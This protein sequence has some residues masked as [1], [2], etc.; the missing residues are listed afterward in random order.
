MIERSEP[1]GIRL[2]GVSATMQDRNRGDDHSGARCRSRCPA[3]RTDDAAR[4]E[5]LRQDHDVAHDRGLSG[6][7]QRQDLDRRARRHACAGE[8]AR[9]RLRVPEL[10]PVP[11]SD[12]F[13]QRRLRAAG[14][15]QIR[16]AKSSAAVAEAL[17]LV[18]LAGFGERLPNELS[19]GQQQRV[20]LARAIVIQPARP[21]VRRAAF[22]PGC[23]TAGLDAR[24]DQAP[25]AGAQDHDG[26]RHARPGRG[27]GD[28][29]PHRRD[30]GRPDRPARQRRSACTGVR[31]PPSSRALSDGPICCTPSSRA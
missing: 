10:C 26:L 20:A 12:D 31:R 8:P 16:A 5:R 11:A 28:F 15:Q 4:P 17:E 14:A 7:E 2:E 3:G 21:A 9:H 25:A 18:G 6:A 19:G 1:A 27:D 23:E 22:Q 24:R 13:R 30:G 29:R